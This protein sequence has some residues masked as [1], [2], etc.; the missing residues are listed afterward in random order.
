MS[1]VSDID[2]AFETFDH[3]E[4]WY[5]LSRYSMTFFYNSGPAAVEKLIA[6]NLKRF[7]HKIFCIAA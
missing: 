5:P 7:M 2:C 6:Q 1:H 4:V 3:C